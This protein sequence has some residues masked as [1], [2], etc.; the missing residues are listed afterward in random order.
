[1]AVRLLGGYYRARLRGDG[2]RYQ[3]RVMPRRAYLIDV[4]CYTD[5]PIKYNGTAESTSLRLAVPRDADG[6][7]QHDLTP[8]LRGPV[9]LSGRK[10]R[11]NAAEQALLVRHAKAL[12]K[13]AG[14]EV[15]PLSAMLR[16]LDKRP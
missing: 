1:M 13:A 15:L 10:L 4:S 8:A 6:D 2:R 12:L 3:Y 7:P 5:K 16:I 11:P 14:D 9:I